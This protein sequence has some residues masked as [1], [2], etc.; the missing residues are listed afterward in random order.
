MSRGKRQRRSLDQ[1]NSKSELR[2]LALLQEHGA[3]SVMKAARLTFGKDDPDSVRIV[4]KRLHQLKVTKRVRSFEKT[5]VR[6]FEALPGPQPAVV[7][8]APEPS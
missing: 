7:Q 5:G 4:S 2:L 3:L 6:M 8:P 1:P